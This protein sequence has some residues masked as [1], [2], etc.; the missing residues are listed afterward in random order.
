[1][2]F[3]S[4]F[5]LLFQPPSR[6]TPWRGRKTA[7][8]FGPRCPQTPLFPV[9]YG[10]SE[11]CLFLNVISPAEKNAQGYPVMFWVHGGGFT[12]GSADL[13]DAEG[14]AENLASRG[15]LVVTINYRLGAL[16]KNFIFH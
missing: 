11:N 15:V 12:M 9:K 7:L 8:Q 6:P 16:G 13:F 4:N 10:E 1:M 3:Y 5:I 14:I 2:Q